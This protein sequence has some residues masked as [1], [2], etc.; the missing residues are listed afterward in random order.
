MTANPIVY[1]DRPGRRV[2]DLRPC[3][4][5][6]IP[7]LGFSSFT[8]VRKG[9][10]FHFHPD[11]MEFCL[12]LKGNLVFDTPKREYAFLPGRIFVSPARQPHHAQPGNHHR[13]G[14]SRHPDTRG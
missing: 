4:V 14:D 12:C 3:G 10:D 2:L 11:C 6:C 13:G 1:Q 7:V 9:P 5:D 8:S